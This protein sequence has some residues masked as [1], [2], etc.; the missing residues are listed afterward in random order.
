MWKLAD[1]VSKLDE[2]VREGEPRSGVVREEA[3]A[4]LADMEQISSA[5]GLGDWPSNHPQVSRNV[6]AFREELAAARRALE[7]EPPSYFLAG[8]VSGACTHCHNA[9]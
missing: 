3:I 9:P 6:G 5:L 2:L 1:R 7:M 8:S 4:L